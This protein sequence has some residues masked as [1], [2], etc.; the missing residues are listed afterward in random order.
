M[1]AHTGMASVEAAFATRVAAAPNIW[2]KRNGVLITDESDELC[3]NCGDHSTE[4][5]CWMLEVD[6]DDARHSL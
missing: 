6:A 5:L 1:N 3:E 2:V 4:C